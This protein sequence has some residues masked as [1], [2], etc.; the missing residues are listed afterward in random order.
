MQEAHDLLDD[1]GSL[2]PKEALEL[3]DARYADRRVRTYAVQCLAPMTD[4]DLELYILQLV[5]VLK[6]EQ[7][8][9]SPLA[10]FLMVRALRCPNVI[11]HIFFWHLKVCA[12]PLLSISR[13]RSHAKT[14][15]REFPEP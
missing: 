5:Q 8:H 2:S 9:D 11:G 12:P 10:C 6:Y 13:V 14:S 3:L 7:D 1:W 15:A 4:E